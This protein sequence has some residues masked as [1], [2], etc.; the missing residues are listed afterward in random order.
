MTTTTKSKSHPKQVAFKIYA[1][2]FHIN[3]EQMRI[4]CLKPRSNKNERGCKKCSC[5]H[6]YV[7]NY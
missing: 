1:E 3:N 5:N 7:P 4:D 2:R 6:F